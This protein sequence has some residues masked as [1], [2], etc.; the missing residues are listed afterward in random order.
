MPEANVHSET[1]PGQ[2]DIYVRFAR[3]APLDQQDER[4]QHGQGKCVAPEGNGLR[5]EVVETQAQA[6][7]RK[8]DGNRAANQHK[9][10]EPFP[11][12]RRCHFC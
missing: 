12:C 5:A 1:D 2:D 8:S 7:R 10:A 6:N 11:A 4:S 3:S 9:H